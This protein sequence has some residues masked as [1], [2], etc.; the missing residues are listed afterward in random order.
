[1][2]ENAIPW[3]ILDEL[4]G[5]YSS[6]ALLQIAVATLLFL[7]GVGG[8]ILSRSRCNFDVGGGLLGHWSNSTFTLALGELCFRGI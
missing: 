8:V 1:L 2:S 7:E 5:V 6:D 3:Q 4:E